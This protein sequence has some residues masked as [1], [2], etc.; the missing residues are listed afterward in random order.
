MYRIIMHNNEG[1]HAR[2]VEFHERH[3]S[4]KDVAGNVYVVPYTTIRMVI[5]S[6]EET[7][8]TEQSDNDKSGD[9]ERS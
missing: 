3:L 7:G 5:K 1:L 9:T 6:K 8:D 2:T 4:F